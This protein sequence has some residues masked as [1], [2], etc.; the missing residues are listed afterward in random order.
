[1]VVENLFLGARHRD[2][3]PVEPVVHQTS[4]GHCDRGQINDHDHE[5]DIDAGGQCD[6]SPT[7]VN[8]DLL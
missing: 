5:N 6:R 2:L 7:M 8:P 1:V 3:L 4:G